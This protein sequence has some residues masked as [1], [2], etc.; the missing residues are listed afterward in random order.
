MDNVAT[1]AERRYIAEGVDHC[2]EALA[3]LTATA[4]AV[5]RI[6]DS[7]VG[8]L[9]L[10]SLEAVSHLEARLR[11]LDEAYRIAERHRADLTL[12]ESANLEMEEPVTA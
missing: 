5:T 11:L 12:G 1:S 7:D 6:P 3:L 10:A 8:Q 9:A 2:R 4:A